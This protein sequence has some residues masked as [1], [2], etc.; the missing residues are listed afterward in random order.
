M[1]SYTRGQLRDQNV[2]VKLT[3]TTF[4]QFKTKDLA[5]IAGISASDLAVLGQIPIADDGSGLPSGAT[6]FL[7]ANSPKPARVGKK[8]NS[9]SGNV[10]SNIS[11]FCSFDA[12]TNALRAGWNLQKQ[13]LTV[14]LSITGKQITAIAELSN[15]VLYCFSLNKADFD[16]YKEQLG[17]VGAETITT[18]AERARLVRGSSLPKPGKAKLKLENGKT[19]ST[20]CSH[21]APLTGGFSRISQERLI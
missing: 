2:A 5:S 3:A 16:Q 20:F 13:A 8:L 14:S 9:N 10:Q 21:F 17:L 4:Y 7:R 15:D 19:F 12:L 11:T 18:D 6:V 1:P